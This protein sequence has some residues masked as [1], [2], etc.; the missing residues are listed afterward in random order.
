M[1]VEEHS[2]CSYCTSVSVTGLASRTAAFSASNDLHRCKELITHRP[3]QKAF[4]MNVSVGE[5]VRQLDSARNACFFVALLL[6]CS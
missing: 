1:K 2:A 5:L 3:D 6:F 4:L